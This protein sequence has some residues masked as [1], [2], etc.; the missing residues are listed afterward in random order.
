MQYFRWDTR[1][2]RSDEAIRRNQTY[3]GVAYLFQISLQFGFNY[4]T[5]ENCKAAT[6]GI[7]L[8]NLVPNNT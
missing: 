5:K 4:K 3:G 7:L 6:F 2:F 8:E 1:P